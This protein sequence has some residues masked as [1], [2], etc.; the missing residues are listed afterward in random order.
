MSVSLVRA[1]RER[2][3]S[4]RNVSR[5]S[6][7]FYPFSGG[8]NLIDSPL[9]STPGQ[10]QNALNYEMGFEGG[11][12]RVKGYEKFDGVSSVSNPEYWKL[13]FRGTQKPWIRSSTF[14]GLDGD[15]LFHNLLDGR[16]IIEGRT[17]G[18][19]GE[20]LAIDQPGGYGQNIIWR[21]TR[22]GRTGFLSEGTFDPDP[23]YWDNNP[24]AS[25]IKIERV[26]DG[27]YLWPTGAKYGI[28]A[29]TRFE[30]DAGNGAHWI[31]SVG[32]AFTIAVGDMLYMSMY[33]KYRDGHS[34]LGGAAIPGKARGG[35]R[36]SLDGAA[37][38]WDG[39]A[40]PY[41]DYRIVNGT[42]FAQSAHWAATGVDVL[43]ND[44]L[45]LWGRTK[46]AWAA[47]GSDCFFRFAFMDANTPSTLLLSFASVDGDYL[48]AGAPGVIKLLPET[49]HNAVHGVEKF[50]DTAKWKKENVTVADNNTVWGSGIYPDFSKVTPTATTAD[51]RIESEATWPITSGHHVIPVAMGDQ[52]MVEGYFKWESGGADGVLININ[53]FAIAD[54]FL[55]GSFV[56]RVAINLENGGTLYTNPAN[57]NVESIEIT[58]V[59]TDIYYIKFVS[60]PLDK[61]GTIVDVHLA[62]IMD[63]GN[64]TSYVSSFDGTAGQFMLLTGVRIEI[65]SDD[66]NETKFRI[67]VTDAADETVYTG[68][69]ILGGAAVGA[70][71]ENEPLF[72]SA[73]NNL[74]TNELGTYYS[75]QAGVA[76]GPAV[77]N[78]EIITAIDTTYTALAATAAANVKDIVG[79]GPIRGAWMHRG[80][81]Y[82]FRDSQDGT[83]AIMWQA[84]G[85]G[86]RQ[87]GHFME[88]PFDTGTGDE[89]AIDDQITDQSTNAT[90]YVRYVDTR[91][92]AW[93][94]D[95][96]GVIYCHTTR[97]PLP[98]LAF[99]NNNI[100]ENL[101]N[102]TAF[103]TVDGA[104]SIS[105]LPAGGR[106]EFRNA[107]LF[108]STEKQRMYFVSGVSQ[109]YEFF[110]VLDI[111]RPV[112]TGMVNDK[113]THLAIHNYHLFLSFRGGSVQLSGDG[114]P[115]SW[116][117]ITGASEIAVGDEISGFNEEVGNSLFIFTRNKS[118][119]LQG[120]GR[121]NFSLDDFNINAGAHEWSVQR[122]GLGF[123]FD[124]RGFTSLLQTQRSGS[125]NFQEN[126]QSELIQPL[127]TDLV[128]NSEVTCSHLIR[129]QNIYRCYFNDGRIVSVGFR[130]H[131]VSGHMTVQYPF[132][133]NVC[134]SEEDA[135]GSER[136]LVGTTEGQVFELE[137]GPTFDGDDVR[138]FI[139]SVLYMSGSPGKMKKYTHMR[140]D[141]TFS[142]PLT[143]MGRVEYD[144]DD[145]NW[146][147]GDEL[148]FTNDSAG[149]YWDDFVWDSFIWDKTTSGNPQTKL[150]G[151]G[152]NVSIYLHTES[153][154][155]ASHTLRG[156]TLQWVPRRDDRRT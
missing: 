34:N 71:E 17:N 41:I 87:V 109:A 44:V 120:T 131:E 134:C 78:G 35:I 148:D 30:T 111:L 20:L 132:V 76:S 97:R 19:R 77:R 61:N 47:V 130:Q 13:P 136:I 99:A 139:R 126:A 60:K 65:M 80:I 96:A 29:L 10:C 53:G 42:V 116:T 37:G 8:L 2:T 50:N 45:R 143:L 105:S 58:A 89:P 32:Q 81:G 38:A 91:S 146:N 107:N 106:Y 133:A 40:Q 31:E 73:R 6:S 94:V 5:E 90:G 68:S 54:S 22:F 117:V 84:T 79:S 26:I 142:G 98:N 46:I 86:W 137:K 49:V 152:T 24:D 48:H 92:G 108:G 1:R 25:G 75:P 70:Y 93:G 155:D 83:E 124:D 36:L 149:G 112:V 122:I 88:V 64:E 95:A 72:A 55:D 127:V 39:G 18:G 147:L 144:F 57:T 102:T 140:L 154:T 129:E 27:D 59:D 121:A 66:G 51:H 141:G 7:D 12:K 9:S 3:R 125:V 82:A 69:L 4:L 100:L 101:E 135:L 119:V 74:A 150:E 156:A 123:F 113:P 118:F 110:S 33:V 52:I 151:E 14:A 56:V 11:Y 153:K 138:A 43:E 104:S 62:C 23:A 15:S 63:S 21:N 16:T 67:P 128:R 28:V 145:P 103:A 114:D 115:H 85:A